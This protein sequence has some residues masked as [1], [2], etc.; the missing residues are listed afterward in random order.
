M[1]GLESEPQRLYMLVWEPNRLPAWHA[2]AQSL[3]DVAD[4]RL[5]HLHYPTSRQYW[6]QQQLSNAEPTHREEMSPTL[7]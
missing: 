6:L 1:I 5:A 3:V 4:K 2:L 7:F